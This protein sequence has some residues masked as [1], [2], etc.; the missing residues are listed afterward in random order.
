MDSE[1]MLRS[2]VTAKAVVRNVVAVVTAPLLPGPVVGLPASRAMI[3][4]GTLS[5]TVLL[6]HV[7]W[8]FLAPLDLSMLLVMWL[9]PL[10]RVLLL[11]PVSVGLLLSSILP[12]PVLVLPLLLNMFLLLV[13]A[14]VL[15]LLRSLLVR[16]PLLSSLPGVRL[17]LLVLAWLLVGVVLLFAVLLPLRVRR[18]CDSENQRQNCCAD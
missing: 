17:G 1:P 7:I 12:L 3:L 13:L 15:R 9:S 8:L 16:L 2:E 5:D 18:S 14:L 4:P 10:L 11:L 6:P